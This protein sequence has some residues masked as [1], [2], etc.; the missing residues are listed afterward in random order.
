MPIPKVNTL[1][2]GSLDSNLKGNET[3]ALLAFTGF[4]DYKWLNTTVFVGP[5]F[6]PI[7]GRPYIRHRFARPGVRNGPG[8]IA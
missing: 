7:T 6:T 5:E 3:Y 4:S 2:Y 8:L 1:F